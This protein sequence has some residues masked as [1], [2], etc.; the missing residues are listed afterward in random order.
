M[1]PEEL[2]RGRYLVDRFQ[3]RA[4]LDDMNGKTAKLLTRYAKSKGQNLRELKRLWNAMTQ[5]E[6]FLKR[7]E[8]LGELQS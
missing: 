6:R 3:A 4:R 5:K 7:Q 1:A 8:M 2:A